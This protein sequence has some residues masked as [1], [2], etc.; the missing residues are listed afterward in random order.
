MK[1]ILFW[2]VITPSIVLLW[3]FMG[4]L[5]VEGWKAFKEWRERK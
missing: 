2:L 3:V 1:D 4:A 5:L